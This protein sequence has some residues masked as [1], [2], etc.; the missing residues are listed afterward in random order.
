MLDVERNNEKTTE[1]DGH[2]DVLVEDIRNK[3]LDAKE[4]GIDIGNAIGL[5]MQLRN[6]VLEKNFDTNTKTFI[7]FKSAA[8]YRDKVFKE[9]YGEINELTGLIYA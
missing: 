2:I 5:L 9:I 4:N 7:W 8:R 3:L 6:S 1:K